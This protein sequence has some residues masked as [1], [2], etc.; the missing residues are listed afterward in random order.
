MD[1]LGRFARTQDSNKSNSALEQLQWQLK[2]VTK[3]FVDLS[4]FSVQEVSLSLSLSLSLVFQ[5]S[6]YNQTDL[7]NI[8]KSR[9][10]CV[11]VCMCVCVCV[12]RGAMTPSPGVKSTS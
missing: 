10:A 11:C 6:Y 7:V 5:S 9:R 4:G 8:V 12:L 2:I 3:H 1:L